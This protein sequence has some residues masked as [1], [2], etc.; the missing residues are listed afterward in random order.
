MILSIATIAEKSVLGV[1]LREADT[2]CAENTNT[3]TVVIIAH[4]AIRTLL[5]VGRQMALALLRG[6]RFGRLLLFL[7]LR[8]DEKRAYVMRRRVRGGTVDKP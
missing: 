4:D 2:T 7:L 8:F 5:L 6:L 3:N 1:A